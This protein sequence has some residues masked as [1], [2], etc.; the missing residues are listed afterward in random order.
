[1]DNFRDLLVDLPEPRTETIECEGKSYTFVGRDDAEL[2]LSPFSIRKDESTLVAREWEGAIRLGFKRQV[3]IAPALVWKVRLV[4]QT[5]QAPDGE[6][7]PTEIEI[8]ALATLRGRI[9]AEMF[10]AALKVCNMTE[11]REVEEQMEAAAEKN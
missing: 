9:F 3:K 2:Q 5:I 7:P 6:K 1:M 11:A 4:A 8:A 10:L